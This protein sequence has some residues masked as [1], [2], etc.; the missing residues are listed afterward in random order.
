MLHFE[1]FFFKHFINGLIIVQ[2]VFKY[3]R[4]KLIL[5][6][7]THR[8]SDE[9]S[10]NKSTGIMKWYVSLLCL[11]A[12]KCACLS[13]GEISSPEI[14]I[15]ICIKKYTWPK[16][17]SNLALTPLYPNTKT[18]L[19]QLLKWKLCFTAI[20]HLYLWVLVGL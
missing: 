11:H 5:I 1:F 4:N 12:M 17:M 18:V 16:S 3:H 14:Y 15:D 10:E 2:F 7:K 8:R 9:E 6:T 19:C 20:H 13:A